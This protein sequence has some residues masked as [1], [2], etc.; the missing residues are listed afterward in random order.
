MTSRALNLASAVYQMFLKKSVNEEEVEMEES[1]S[2]TWSQ[3]AGYDLSGFQ[4]R[5]GGTDWRE[6]ATCLQQLEELEEKEEKQRVM[7][8]DSDAG[9][10]MAKVAR[11]SA[12]TLLMYALRFKAPSP[13]PTPGFWNMASAQVR[14]LL[15]PVQ[16]T[17]LTLNDVLN[18]LKG[19]IRPLRYQQ[20][21]TAATEIQREH[22]QLKPKAAM[23]KS[24]ETLPLKPPGS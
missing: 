6:A 20:Y 22:D 7:L 2:A 16:Y 10:S 13:Q 4:V 19:K 3:I 8:I 1:S 17:E 23:V 21:V 14:Q 9:R 18:H 12:N 5:F 15:L 11:T 24:D